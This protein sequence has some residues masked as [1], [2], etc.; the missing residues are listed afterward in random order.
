MESNALCFEADKIGRI[1]TTDDFYGQSTGN[2]SYCFTASVLARPSFYELQNICD[3]PK[4]DVVNV[5][6]LTYL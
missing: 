5:D 6:A 3:Q 4:L 1:V 2:Y